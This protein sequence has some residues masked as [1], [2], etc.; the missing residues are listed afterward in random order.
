MNKKHLV[1]WQRV[2]AGIVARIL[3]RKRLISIIWMKR[4]KNRIVYRP[5]MSLLRKNYMLSN[6]SVMLEDPRIKNPQT[7]EGKL[8]RRRFRVPYPIYEQLLSKLVSP[9]A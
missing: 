1:E 6:W 2:D 7:R 3:A 5:R 9:F 4:K 8:F